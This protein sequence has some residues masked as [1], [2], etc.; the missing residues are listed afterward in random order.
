MVKIATGNLDNTI[1]VVE[2][3]WNR[4]FRGNPFEYF[5]LD[6]YFN[7]YYEADQ[8]FR[9]LFLVFAVLAIFIGCLGLF[10]LSSYTAVQKTKE[11][12]I[13]KVLGSSTS[14]IVQLMFK[15]FLI[16]IGIANLIAWPLSWY[17]LNQWLEN[18][19]YHI[20]VNLL[21]FFVATL[22]VLVIA[23]LTVSFHTF[24]TAKLNPANTLKYE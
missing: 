17:F 22:V 23:F 20:S 16:L 21:S 3:Q 11:I 24:K 5:F 12:G 18:Y 10:G 7:S 6:E 15:D 14:G 4:S 9:N 13:R 2:E 8:S 1:A 19:P